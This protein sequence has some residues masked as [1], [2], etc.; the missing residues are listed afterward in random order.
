MWGLKE[1]GEREG[2][3]REATDTGEKVKLSVR[4][5]WDW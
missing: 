2:R 1:R 5:D 4:R 3:G